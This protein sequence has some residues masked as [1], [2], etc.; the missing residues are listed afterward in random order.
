LNSK[1]LERI[2]AFR[3]AVKWNIAYIIDNVIFTPRIEQLFRK[4]QYQRE[5]RIVDSA[6][7]ILYV[8]LSVISK[9]DAGTGIQRVVRSIYRHLPEVAPA[10]LAIVPIVVHKHRDGYCQ[11][12]G[13]PLRGGPDALFLG[14]DFAT[15]SVVR[16]RG[17]LE[18][19]SRAGGRI[20]FLVHDI[21]PF[22]HPRW[23]TAATRV[24]YRRWMRACA[25]LADGILTVSPHVASQVQSLLR[26]HYRIGALPAMASIAL[27]SNITLSPQ[28]HL[29]DMSR[30]LG[31]AAS[32]INNAVLVVGTLEPRKGHMA[33]LD[34]F[35]ILWDQHVNIPLLLVGKLGWKMSELQSRISNHPHHGRNLYWLPDLDDEGLSGAYAHCR[36]VIAASL[37][38]GYGL[39]LDEALAAG[40]PVLARDIPVFQRHPSA[41]LTHFPKT[42]SAAELAQHIAY[43]YETATRATCTPRLPTWRET[44]RQTLA[45]LGLPVSQPKIND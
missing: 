25:R 43:A 9:L 12:D 8:D 11:E 16:H 42:A 13:T 38:E 41:N 45:A 34:A 28:Q 21:L 33:V 31:T 17:Q 19:F 7:R 1:P 26:N 3:I 37:E 30:K 4:R 5:S 32:R 6:V 2:R 10:H 15:E 23:F 27:G 44:T 35:D 20:W 29:A 40:A 18:A 24:K 14:L 39:P 22:S 36:L